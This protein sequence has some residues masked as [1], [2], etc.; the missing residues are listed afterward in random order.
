MNQNLTIYHNPN[1]SNSRNA[2][3][4]IRQVGIE[5][6]I[7]PY[8]DTPLDKASLGA[9]LDKLA[10]PVRAIV[11]TKEPLYESLGLDN[12][13]L[14]DEQIIG[15]LADNPLLINR[16]I[17]ANDTKAKLCRPPECVLELIATL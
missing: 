16:P 8:L 9:L 2:L 7:V 5:P 14:S 13:N 17:V 4:L 11:R 12:P 15:I 3:A 6:V 1:C 10:L